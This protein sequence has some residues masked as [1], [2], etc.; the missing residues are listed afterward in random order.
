MIRSHGMTSGEVG[1]W[2]GVIFSVCGL[3][4]TYL[5]GYV[6]ERY[7]SGREDIQLR[8]CG[9]GVALIFPFT[10]VFLL[11]PDKHMSLAAFMPML[12]LFHVFIGPMYAIMQRLVTD[13]MRATSVALAMMTANLIGM[14]LGPQVVGILSDAW[15][16]RFGA[17]SLRMAMLVVSTSAVWSGL[18]FWLSSRT[19]KADLARGDAA[20]RPDA[21][22][23]ESAT[24]VMAPLPPLP[25]SR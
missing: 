21:A 19:V 13:E 23:A 15:A 24:D 7:L 5:G 17:D 9:I 25:V 12:F 1:L 11:A 6:A 14:G 18:H 20:A 8:L 22:P 3:I 2:L 16:P 4:G 10:V